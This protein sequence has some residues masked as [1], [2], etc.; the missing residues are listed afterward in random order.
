V[1]LA[2]A[3]ARYLVIAKIC[4]SAAGAVDSVTIQKHAEPTL[5]GNVVATVKTWR[6][7]PETVNGMP[8]PFCTFKNFEFKSD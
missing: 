7:R 3:G 6:F 1:R 8:V 2:T 4:V 5:D